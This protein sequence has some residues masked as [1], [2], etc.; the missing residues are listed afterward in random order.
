[1]AKGCTKK[2]G[3]D[4]K[5]VFSPVVRHT[6]IKVLLAMIAV[7]DME[8]DQLDVKT[9]FLHGILQKEILMVQPEGYVD[10]ERPERV[11]LLKKSLYSLKQSPRQWYLRFDEFITIN[12]FKRC[13]FDCCIYY[14]LLKTHLYIYLLLYVDD[15]LI[16]C[17][18]RDGI[19]A[20]KEL[21]SSEFDIKD[22]EHA[23]KILGM[24]IRRNMKEGTMF[25]LQE[26]YVKKIVKTFGMSVCKSVM[27]PLASHFKLYNMQCAKT[28]EERHEMAKFPYANVVG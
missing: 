21:L 4:F 28:D 2:E 24:N 27:T 23:R 26:N 20:L 19:E 14:K 11:C 22:L 8:L 13:S 18:L 1:M 15:M 3:V 5:Q 12:R 25:L 16:A 10:L 7:Y 6:S 9:A 17:K